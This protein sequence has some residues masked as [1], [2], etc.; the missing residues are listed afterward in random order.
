MPILYMYKDNPYNN[1][2]IGGRKKRTNKKRKF[3]SITKRHNIDD[4]SSDDEFLYDND[5]S[6]NDNKIYFKS[7]ITENSIDK[8]IK[9]I[10][11]KN[12][13]FEKITKNRMIKNAEPKPL[14]LHITSYGGD[15]FAS[16]RGVDAIKRSAIPIYTV[17]D[18]YAASGATL[19]SVVGVKRFMTPNSYMLIHQLSAGSFGK[20]WE[21][22]DDFDN[23]ETLMDDIYNIYL[24]HTKLNIDELKECLSH[25]LWFKCDLSIQYGL[26]DK[27]YEKETTN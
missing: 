23:F 16:F 26:V 1:K 9:I 2:K 10:E 17:I 22:K 12:K 19:L 8:L 14:Y 11:S 4:D 7:K 25:D 6:S 27:V 13:K 21:L 20:Y 5:V 18:G 3:D 15:L 24:R